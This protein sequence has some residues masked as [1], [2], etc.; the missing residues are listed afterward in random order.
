MDVRKSAI[1]LFLTENALFGEILVPKFKIP[2]LNWNLVRLN[3]QNSWLIS[4]F[5]VLYQKHLGKFGP[6]NQ[7]CQF[8][9]KFST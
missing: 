5:S 2:C 1:F 8:K 7:S 6:K 9:L 4:S 3:V